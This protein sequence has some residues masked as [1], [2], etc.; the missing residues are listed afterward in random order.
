LATCHK[1]CVSIRA[2]S[3][4]FCHPVNKAVDLLLSKST[5]NS[6]MD[7]GRILTEER[8][9]IFKVVSF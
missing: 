2:F 4:V 9:E 5:V 1:M 6:N 3:A 8:E 7:G